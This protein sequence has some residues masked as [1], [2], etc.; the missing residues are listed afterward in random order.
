MNVYQI[1]S[2]VTP[3][4]QTPS[5]RI[6]AR[7]AAI[8]ANQQAAQQAAA[9]A[10]SQQAAAQ[11]AAAQAASQQA[12]AQKAAQQ[13]AAAAQK[14]AR[15]PK[16]VAQDKVDKIN[17]AAARKQKSIPINVFAKNDIRLLKNK[18]IKDVWDEL[19]V[20]ENAK[21]L[22]KYTKFLD[23]TLGKVLRATGIAAG[24]FIIIKGYY[25][26]TGKIE[27]YYETGELT[28]AQ[29]PGQTASETFQDWINQS[30]ALL[31]V[32][33]LEWVVHAVADIRIAALIAKGIIRVGGISSAGATLGASVLALLAT[34]AGFLAL[35]TLL[36]SDS[37]RKWFAKEF[38]FDTILAFGSVQSNSYDYLT[39]YFK[40]QDLKRSNFAVKQKEL[41]AQKKLDAAKLTKDTVAITAA[42]KELAAAT[43]AVDDAKSDADSEASR[44]T[45]RQ[46]IRR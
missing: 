16:Q 18:K 27:T 39:D 37:G 36:T 35:E 24:L 15:S 21:G 38:L 6:A 46:Q 14:A 23:S 11:Q 1:I 25:D 45:T 19:K 3:P 12:A 34:E 17:A 10:A 2:E 41:E 26:A 13:Q 4:A 9:Q 43:Q 44:A 33:L 22:A 5:Q 30:N 29:V 28:D 8:A 40:N 42:Q 32:H 20:M 31:Q 7:N